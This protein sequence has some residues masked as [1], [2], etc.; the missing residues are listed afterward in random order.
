VGLQSPRLTSIQSVP[1][2]QN[3]SFDSFKDEVSNSDVY[4][5]KYQH[6]LETKLRDLERRL[7]CRINVHVTDTLH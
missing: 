3:R 6:G 7:A 1:R 2:I 4:L 5:D